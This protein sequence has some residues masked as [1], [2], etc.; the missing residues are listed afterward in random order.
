MGGI[1]KNKIICF[2]I[3]NIVK[4]HKIIIQVKTNKTNIKFVNGY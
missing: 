4:L 2:D 1:L 3:D